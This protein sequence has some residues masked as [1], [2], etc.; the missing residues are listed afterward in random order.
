MRVIVPLPPLEHVKPM[1]RLNPVFDVE[2][3]KFVMS[4]PEI[5]DVRMQH[6]DEKVVSLDHCRTEVIAALDYIFTGV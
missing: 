2:G 1:T 4:T 3:G 6:V 5:A